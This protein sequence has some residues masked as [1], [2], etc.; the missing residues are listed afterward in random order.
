MRLI[1]QVYEG[2]SQS[3]DAVEAT[4]GEIHDPD[5]P[6]PRALHANP[7]RRII[8]GQSARPRIAACVYQFLMAKSQFFA[9][10]RRSEV[11]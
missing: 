7:A 4:P 6:K 5:E 1:I 10:S 2:G 9:G 8:G 3:Q 11:R